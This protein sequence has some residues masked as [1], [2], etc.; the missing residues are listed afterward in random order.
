MTK[1]KICG[2][3]NLEDAL[4]ASDIGADELGFNF[5][6]KSKRY[7]AP[8]FARE[9]SDELDS[10]GIVGVFVNEPIGSLL[11]IV[12]IV[13][14]DGIQL[15]GDEDVSYVSELQQ[16]TK[17]FVVK[18]FRMMPKFNVGEV[19]DWPLDFPLFD[20]HSPQQYGGTGEIFDWEEFGSEIV[21]W[22]PDNAYLAG[23]LTPA[24]V[25]EAVRIVQP[26]AVD[27]A[28]GVESEPGKKDAEKLKAFIEN[29]K[30]A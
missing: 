7:I 16:R 18:A 20:T 21:L 25:A 10:S 5:Y 17:A 13:G 19:V 3:T 12:D 8:K 2:I 15:H 27:V 1:V 14:L 24:N 28:S 23:G 6:E 29:A 26:Y 4:L 22:F 30:N 9:I 11:E